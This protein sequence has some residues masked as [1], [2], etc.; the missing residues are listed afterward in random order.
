M[1]LTA[2][3]PEARYTAPAAVPAGHYRLVDVMASEWTKLRTVR[4]TTYSLIA[5]IV[6]TIGIGVLATAMVAWRWPHLGAGF[7]QS[8]DPV[9]QSL[10]GLLFGQLALGVLGVL[11]VSSEYGTGTIRATLSAVP[12][13]PLVLLAKT[14]VFGAVAFIL[15]EAL[16]FAT[17]LIGQAIL[18]GEAPHASLGQPGVARAVIGGGLYL[19][20]LALLAMGFASI[21]RHTAGAISAFVGVLLILPLILQAFPSSVVNTIG[22]YVPANIGATVTSTSG[23]AGFVGHHSFSPWVGL[24]VLAGY[25]LVSLVIGGWLMV[26]RDA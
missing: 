1:S 12:N 24:A 4:S 6:L 21:I 16:L 19:T 22:R 25:A 26:R 9:R 13:R 10:T 3:L 18:A 8:F 23:S 14:L 5:T 7:Q 17:F 2:R 20:C 11:V 15:S